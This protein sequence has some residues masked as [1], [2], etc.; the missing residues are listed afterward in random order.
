MGLGQWWR[1]TLGS[2]VQYF[3]FSSGSGSGWLMEGLSLR[4][5]E[6]GTEGHS[7]TLL[8]TWI[9]LMTEPPT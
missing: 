8:V 5:K 3:L 6:Q 4:R 9:H 7:D 1:G 2:S